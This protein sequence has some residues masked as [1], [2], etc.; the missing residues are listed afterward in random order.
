L[1]NPE[2]NRRLTPEQF[3]GEIW[4]STIGGIGEIFKPVP[5]KRPENWNI[6]TPTSQQLKT[7][8]NEN[9]SATKINE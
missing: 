9:G 1:P 6:K 3:V 8:I 2:N 5:Y 7:F 4:I